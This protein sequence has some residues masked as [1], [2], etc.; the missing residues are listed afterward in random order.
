MA[1]DQKWFNRIKSINAQLPSRLKI[2]SYFATK[3][4]FLSDV[5]EEPVFAYRHIIDR[6]LKEKK[7]L[8]DDLELEI[9]SCR[10][11][12]PAV[13][14][15]YVKKIVEKRD[16]LRLIE[17]LHTVQTSE[18]KEELLATA[19]ELTERVYG[20]PKLDIFNQ[21]TNGIRV[22]LSGEWEPLQDLAEYRRLQ[23]LFPQTTLTTVPNLQMM[24]AYDS[25]EVGV[26]YT[27]AEQLA[28]RFKEAFIEIGLN[29]WEVK[30]S[31]QKTGGV[32]VRPRNRYVSIPNSGILRNRA[33][34]ITEHNLK[35][36]LAHEV[37]VHARRVEH[38][39]NSGLL[40]LSIGLD[41]YWRGEEGVATYYEQ[42]V[43][44]ASDYAGFSPYFTVGL[45]YG[46]DRG[47]IRRTFSEVFAVLRD[48]YTLDAYGKNL[49]PD[50]LAFL[51]CVRVFKVDPSFVLTRDCVYREGNIAVHQLLQQKSLGDEYLNVGKYDPTN[52]DHVRCLTE[53][54]ILPT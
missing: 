34:P 50:T 35:G 41:K 25:S 26:V 47:G 1:F 19:K 28:K 38:G 18:Q 3:K 22:R 29:E 49:D 13:K 44:G 45:A 46:L 31:E 7:I 27:D 9:L 32:R 33:N 43:T 10:E 48:Y 16:Q 24:V 4:R 14:E 23:H 52:D 37:M 40:L 11:T 5:T 12:L 21:I 42:R 8:L 39:R 15:L 30:I 54:G 17:M 36:L 53:L 2:T 51:S 20:A 6:H